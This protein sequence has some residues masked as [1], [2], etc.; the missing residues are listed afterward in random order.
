MKNSRQKKECKQEIDL[1]QK[2]R[3]KIPDTVSGLVSSCNKEGCFDHVSTEPMPYREAIIDII[4]RLALI[5]YPGYFIK[6]RLDQT[7]LEYYLV[8]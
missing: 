5:L 4:R 3:T 2:F 1:A 6:T 7:N 8:Q